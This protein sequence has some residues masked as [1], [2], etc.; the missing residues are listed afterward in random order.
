MRIRPPSRSNPPVYLDA[1]T[2]VD[3]Y[4]VYED[5]ISQIDPNLLDLVETDPEAFDATIYQIMNMSTFFAWGLTDSMWHHG[6]STPHDLMMEIKKYN[7]EGMI[8]NITAATLVV[9]AEAETRGQAT[10]FFREL[11]G[12]HNAYLLFTAEEAAQFHVQPGA[13]AILSHKMFDWLDETMS[14]EGV[15]ESAT[16]SSS[17]HGGLATTAI[18]VLAGLLLH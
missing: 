8:G 12:E 18:T 10:E 9:D 14:P 13:T 7:I 2:V 15:G 4:R 6:V 11:K 17:I 1:D 3:W 16:D 5:E